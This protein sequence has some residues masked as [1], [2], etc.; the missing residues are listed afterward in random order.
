M[1]PSKSFSVPTVSPHIPSLNPQSPPTLHFMLPFLPP[2]PSPPVKSMYLPL[3]GD[4]CIPLVSSILNLSGPMDYRLV[5]YPIPFK[6]RNG[7]G[8]H[9]RASSRDNAM[10]S[11]KGRQILPRNKD[12]RGWGFSSVVERLPR[13]HKALGSVP[14]S[15]KKKRKQKKKKKKTFKKK[16]K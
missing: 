11:Q 12:I 15:G 5:K 14:S 10:A 16:K 7:G 2:S 13:K 9:L 4:P 1:L 8:H 6:I 3:P